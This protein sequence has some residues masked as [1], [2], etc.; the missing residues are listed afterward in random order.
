MQNTPANEQ[1]YAW[2]FS[3]AF[4]AGVGYFAGSLLADTLIWRPRTAVPAFLSSVLLTA[5]LISNYL[6]PGA[7]LHFGVQQDWERIL[8]AQGQYIIPLIVVQTCA[9]LVSLFHKGWDTIAGFMTAPTRRFNTSSGPATSKVSPDPP[10]EVSRTVPHRPATHRRR[11]LRTSAGTY[12][13]WS[14]GLLAGISTLTA[15]AAGW[16][17][18][19][20]FGISLAII[21]T[22]SIVI[23]TIGGHRREDPRQGQVR[24]ETD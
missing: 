12:P 14:R 23:M 2:I 24:R 9:F 3:I 13:S 6:M 22:T 18:A 10:V 16:T 8:S 15:T 17:G 5:W 4:N 1:A 11:H 21:S 20:V 19:G 7:L